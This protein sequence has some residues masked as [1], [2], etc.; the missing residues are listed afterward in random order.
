MNRLH[1]VVIWDHCN[2]IGGFCG[3]TTSWGKCYALI[4]RMLIFTMLLLATALY[5]KT[6]YACSM[7][8]RVQDLLLP[9]GANLAPDC[10]VTGHTV[11]FPGLFIMSAISATALLVW[12]YSQKARENQG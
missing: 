4:A 2:R 11:N 3:V 12:R 1:A 10:S 7:P 6:A 5:P 9:W 8:Y